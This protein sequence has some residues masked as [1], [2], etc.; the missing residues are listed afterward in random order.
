MATS[1]KAPETAPSA[2]Q[3]APVVITESVVKGVKMQVVGSFSENA[4]ETVEQVLWRRI[5]TEID[6]MHRLR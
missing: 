4:T 2:K 6:K 5:K 1:K 3:A